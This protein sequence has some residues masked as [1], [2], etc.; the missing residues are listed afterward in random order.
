MGGADQ[1]GGAGLIAAFSGMKG[2]PEAS[3]IVD[4][5]RKFACTRVATLGGGLLLVS[6]S[7]L[8]RPPPARR[9]WVREG[10]GQI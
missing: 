8:E 10:T 5:C 4:V 7:T 3:I 6:Y 1:G 9:W 2:Q